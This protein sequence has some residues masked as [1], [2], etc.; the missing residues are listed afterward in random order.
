M[1][2]KQVA[3]FVL[4]HGTIVE[5]LVLLGQQV[6]DLGKQFLGAQCD[7]L[8]VGQGS[9]A[10]IFRTV[11]DVVVECRVAAALSHLVDGTALEHVSLELG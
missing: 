11:H 6:G 5:D 1:L 7:Q 3:D 4:A 2:G 10:D 9:G 8:V